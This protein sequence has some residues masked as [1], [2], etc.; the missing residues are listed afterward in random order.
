MD[1]L[2]GA[3]DILRVVAPVLG[4]AVGGPLGGMVVGKLSE[5]LLGKSDGTEEEV[6]AAIQKIGR[7]HV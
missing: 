3:G 6:A 1:L 2:K 7:A 4:T 5:A